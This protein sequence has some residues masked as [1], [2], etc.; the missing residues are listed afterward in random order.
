MSFSYTIMLDSTLL[1]MRAYLYKFFSLF[2]WHVFDSLSL[3]QLKT[4]VATKIYVKFGKQVVNEQM[5][6]IKY[7]MFYGPLNHKPSSA[8]R[9]RQK[10]KNTSKN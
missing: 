5:Q 2:V 1:N 4:E 3:S 9:V 10:E 7:Q 6:F 8:K